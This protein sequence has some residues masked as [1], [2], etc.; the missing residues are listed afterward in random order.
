MIQNED[1]EANL[2][3]YRD[4]ILDIAHH[5]RKEGKLLRIDFDESL[6][7]EYDKDMTKETFY[8]ITLKG[9]VNPW[10]DLNVI[11]ESTTEL[12]GDEDQP[13]EV[14]GYIKKIKNTLVTKNFA[15]DIQETISITEASFE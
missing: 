13:Q 14:K 8:P 15:Y 3:S 12:C 11:V 2:C 4:D 5:S 7:S 6:I 1:D 9:N 10:N